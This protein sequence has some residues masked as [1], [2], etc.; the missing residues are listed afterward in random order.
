[1]MTVLCISSF[2]LTNCEHCDWLM[3][4]LYSFIS[5]LIMLPNSCHRTV[6]RTVSHYTSYNRWY[7]KWIKEWRSLTSLRRPK[8]QK[9][10]ERGGDG[11]QD[12]TSSSCEH[13]WPLKTAQAKAIY[14]C[15]QSEVTKSRILFIPKPQW[16]HVMSWPHMPLN[17]LYP[18]G[19]AYMKTRKFEWVRSVESEVKRWVSCEADD[20]MKTT[21]NRQKGDLKLH[22]TKHWGCAVQLV[23]YSNSRHLAQAHKIV[24]KTNKT[25]TKPGIT[26]VRKV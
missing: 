5:H 13:D 23:T 2:C 22:R 9:G 17:R 8:R 4:S 24:Q 10:S 18:L 25:K 6:L 16:H 20:R 1:M 3:A 19:L 11:W 26:K 12:Q 7:E 14:L 21:Q 15:L